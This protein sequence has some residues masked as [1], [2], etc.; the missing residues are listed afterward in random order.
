MWRR[1]RG[2]TR[3]EGFSL[4]EL[5]IVVAIIGI[6]AAV[7]IPNLLSAMHKARQ[8][9]TMSDMKALGSAIESVSTD[10]V[11]YPPTDGD[12]GTDCATPGG[13]MVGLQKGGWWFQSPLI[14]DGWRRALNYR[15]VGVT[16]G[17]TTDIGD[18]NC[19]AVWSNP[20]ATHY[21]LR[22]L[23][24]DGVEDCTHAQ[25]TGSVYLPEGTCSAGGSKT[26]QGFTGFDCDIIFAGGQFIAFPEG[27]QK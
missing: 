22:S 9:R 14:C 26:C 23:G 17:G 5:L 16:G 21:S 27:M 20:W 6:I 18:L 1:I 13:I 7:A 8:K 25:W 2:R 11:A 24:R 15:G 3:R 10:C 12:L 19:L 4:I